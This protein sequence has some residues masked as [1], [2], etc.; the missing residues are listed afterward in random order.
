MKMNPIDLA[1]DN[2]V[3]VGEQFLSLDHAL[4]V[5]STLAD[6]QA[7]LLDSNSLI[8]RKMKSLAVSLSGRDVTVNSS[9]F[10]FLG[11]LTSAN[12]FF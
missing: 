5:K 8:E 9:V 11:G 3:V 6:S 10:Y 7:N 2:F 12:I 4:R 1:A